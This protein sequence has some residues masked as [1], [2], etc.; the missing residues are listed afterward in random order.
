M[1]S[2]TGHLSVIPKL[3]SLSI[4]RESL[5]LELN[6]R[7]APKQPLTTENINLGVLHAASNQVNIQ[8]GCFEQAELERLAD[9]LIDA[10]VM[11][12]HQKQELPI[13]RVFKADLITRDGAPW[14]R[15]FFYWSQ[16]HPRAEE[17]RSGIDSGIYRE[18]SLGFL[19]HRPECAICRE[20]MRRCRHRVNEVVQVGTR[21]L[22]AFYYYKE[23]QKV[24]EISL[25]YR[26]AV[27]GTSVSTL[28]IDS[29][30]SQSAGQDICRDKG[31]FSPKQFEAYQT[32]QDQLHLRL[33]D[34][35]AGRWLTLTRFD[36]KRLN[37][38][39][40]FEI[41]APAQWPHCCH[42]S[43]RLT[44][45]GSC[46]VQSVEADGAVI[47][48]FNGNSLNGLYRIAAEPNIAT[49]ETTLFFKRIAA[50]GD[51]GGV[52]NE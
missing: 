3:A 43:L 40:R 44:D 7:I 33:K 23:I 45:R 26:G 22:R 5:L 30:E 39:C 50:A 14:L 11:V 10:P 42:Q 49:G 36:P 13:G 48:S 19:Y 51:F 29:R 37:A 38:G 46:R 34:N 35:H 31:E 28:K 47:L 25:V 21:S 15:A 6:R 24:L 52:F 8:G 9:L 17:L 27:E 12:G 2:L 1:Y 16:L 20:D 4:D 41:S 18:C 32:D